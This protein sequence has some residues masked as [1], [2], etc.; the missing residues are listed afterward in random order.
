M[1]EILVAGENGREYLVFVTMSGSVSI[2][3]PTLVIHSERDSRHL[4]RQLQRFSIDVNPQTL[5]CFRAMGNK[6]LIR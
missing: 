3:L 2:L 4:S 6:P 5:A 1:E